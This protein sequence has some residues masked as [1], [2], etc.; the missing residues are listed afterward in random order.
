MMH[1]YVLS[2]A[3]LLHEFLA[4]GKLNCNYRNKALRFGI[5][6]IKNIK[7]TTFGVA[8]SCFF[9]YLDAAFRT[10]Q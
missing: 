6:T 5:L 9:V 3:A 2:I 10:Y 8:A 4:V 7:I 1:H